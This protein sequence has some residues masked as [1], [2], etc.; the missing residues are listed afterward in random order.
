MV[1]SL[2]TKLGSGNE[3]Q[4]DSELMKTYRGWQKICSQIILLLLYIPRYIQIRRTN[5]QKYNK[6]QANIWK[7]KNEDKTTKNNSYL[8]TNSYNIQEWI[9][10]L[11]PFSN[12]KKKKKKLA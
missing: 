5:C 10:W 2:V 11:K 1:S 3:Y 8:V 9:I 6:W 7:K 4:K 12:K